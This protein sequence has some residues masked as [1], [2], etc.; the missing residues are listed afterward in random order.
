MPSYAMPGSAGCGRRSVWPAEKSPPA[1]TTSSSSAPVRPPA[2]LM[3]RGRSKA[4]SLHLPPGSSRDRR[5]G[6]PTF[7]RPFPRSP[8]TDERFVDGDPRPRRRRRPRRPCPHLSAL[9]QPVP[10][11]DLP[12]PADLQRLLPRVA[13][14]PRRGPWHA[15]WPAA[16]LPLP[17]LEPWG[18]GSAVTPSAEGKPAWPPA[19]SRPTTSVLADGK[20]QRARSPIGSQAKGGRGRTPAS[21]GEARWKWISIGPRLEVARVRSI[22]GPTITATPLSSRHSRAAANSG[23]SPASSFPPGNSSRPGASAALPRRLPTR[24]RPS[25]MTTATAIVTGVLTLPVA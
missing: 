10:R 25:Q 23:L 15:P 3:E 13:S 17:S 7:P 4:C 19:R 2:G 21:T 18:L 16:D 1:T 14:I 24:T 9:R 6:M 8:A 5:T 11:A 20:W 22:R 12:V